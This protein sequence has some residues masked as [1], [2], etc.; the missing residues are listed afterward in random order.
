MKQEPTSRRSRILT[1]VLVVLLLNLSYVL[2]FLGPLS[3]LIPLALGYGLL[4]VIRSRAWICG[5]LLVAANP[6]TV[7]LSSGVRD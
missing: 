4:V 1:A 3:W 7:L 6:L 5:L 2:A